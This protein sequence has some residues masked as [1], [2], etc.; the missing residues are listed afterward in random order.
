MEPKR[1]AELR[2]DAGLHL[3]AAGAWGI[4]PGRAKEYLGISQKLFEL[5]A[6]IDRLNAEIAA[7]QEWRSQFPTINPNDATSQQ[8][9]DYARQCRDLL[10]QGPTSHSN[11]Q[12][13][14]VE[15]KAKLDALEAENAE[16]RKDKA[17]LDWLDSIKATWIREA[18]ARWTAEAIV[19]SRP[20]RHEIDEN[21]NYYEEHMLPD[22]APPKPSVGFIVAWELPTDQKDERLRDPVGAIEY[23]KDDILKFAY[24]LANCNDLEGLKVSVQVFPTKDQPANG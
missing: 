9:I 4:T 19:E 24:Y 12:I 1:L 15:A 8:I 21:I 3:A 16:L 6:E 7:W 2:E 5:I 13:D 18:V 11:L 23:Q 22:I 10:T 14:L 20:I 17:R